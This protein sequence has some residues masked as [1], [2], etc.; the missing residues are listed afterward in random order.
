ML[1]E[2]EVLSVTVDGMRVKPAL[3]VTQQDTHP[4]VL[5]M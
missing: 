1:M 3:L 4:M 2:A 5:R